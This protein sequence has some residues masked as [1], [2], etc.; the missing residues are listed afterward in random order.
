VFGINVDPLGDVFTSELPEGLL[1]LAPPA[2]ALPAP[3]LT[4][5]L[6]MPVVVPA[7]AVAAAG[8]LVPAAAFACE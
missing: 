6:P 2:D 4:P 3:V 5:P 8:A 1:T 7:V